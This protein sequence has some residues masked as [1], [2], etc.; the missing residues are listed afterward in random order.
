MGLMIPDRVRTVRSPKGG[1]VAG[2]GPGYLSPNGVSLVAVQEN[3]PP[4]ASTAIWVGIAAIVMMFA[5]LTSALIVRQGASADW[6]HFVLPRILYLNTAALLLSSFTLEMF[7]RRLRHRA[8]SVAEELRASR[9]MYATLGLGTIFV[10]GQY[11]AW[12]QLNGDGLYMASNPS[13]SFFYVLTGAHVLHLLGGIV[14]LVYVA[15]MLKR[16]TLRRSTLRVATRYWHFMDVLWL[17]L[18]GLLWRQL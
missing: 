16:H 15:A 3:A 14:A 5:A 18:L 1:R 17:Y 9:W 6:H 11:L 8:P 13:H 2:N 7:S 10:A 4:P 12:H